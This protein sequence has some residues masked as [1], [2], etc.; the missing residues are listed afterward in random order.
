MAMCQR[1]VVTVTQRICTNERR[2]EG[3]YFGAEVSIADGAS[4]F[5]KA[6]ALSGR[7][8]NWSP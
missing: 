6:L 8:P 4:A 5:E 7:D 2:G 1:C 3:N